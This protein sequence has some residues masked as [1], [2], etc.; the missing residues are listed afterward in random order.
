MTTPA[1]RPFSTSTSFTRACGANFDTSRACGF[2]HRLR[3]RAHAADGVAPVALHAVHLA[4]AMM[5][6]HI[7]GARRV[8]ARI[9][10]D[11]GIEAES[12]LDRRALEPMIEIIA[13][14]GGEDFEHVAF[15][16]EPETA[17]PLCEFSGA[18]KLPQPVAGAMWNVR[19]RLLAT[20][21]KKSASASSRAV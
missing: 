8:G 7:G 2:R 18:E 15:A 12:R 10:A 4:E 11:D 5:Q 6:Q 16:F 1:A 14:G 19:R 3:D 21:R 17:Q 20:A 13:S 9:I